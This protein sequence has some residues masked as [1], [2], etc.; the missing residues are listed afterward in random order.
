MSEIQ[1]V[2]MTWYDQNARDLPWRTEN[3]TPWGV[4]VSEIMLAQTPVSRVE[5]IWTQWMKRW[6]TPA[7]L[8]RADPA[9]VIRA[10]DRLGYPRRALWLHEAARTC[11]DRFGGNVPETYDELRALKGVGDYTASAVLAFAYGQRAIVLDTNVRRVLA[12]L[13]L[14]AQAPKPHITTAERMLAEEKVPIDDRTAAR[15]SIAVM[16]FGALICTATNPQCDSCPVQTSCAWNNA[17]R[18]A[19]P[20]RKSQKFTGTDRQVRG[21]LMAVLR[22][23]SE[24]VPR[25]TLDL[26]WPDAIQRERALDG[27]VADGLVDP[28]SHNHFALPTNK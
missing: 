22:A 2:L 15:W 7:D 13:W 6:P 11:V 1:S 4:L 25:S 20:A 27:L 16:E 17:G 23:T 9:Q 18:P 24:P 26:V 5:P 28:I 3:R 19:G 14:G 8:A 12:R 10:W 21:K